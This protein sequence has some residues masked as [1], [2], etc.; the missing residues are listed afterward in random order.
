MHEQ[1]IRYLMLSGFE[2]ISIYVTILKQYDLKLN[3]SSH[4]QQHLWSTATAGDS[5]LCNWS[6]ELH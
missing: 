5:F 3:W 6:E 4:A 2:T 1:E